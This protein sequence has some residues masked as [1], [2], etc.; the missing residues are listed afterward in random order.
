MNEENTKTQEGKTKKCFVIMPISDVEGYPKGHFDRV[1]KHVIVPAC[2]KTGYEA[3]RADGTS[4]ANV[5]IVDILKNALDCEMAIC[6]LSARN[7]NVFYELGF[8]QAFD[9]KTVLMI[10]DKTNRPFDISAIRSFTYDS[11]L[12]I[13]LVDKAISD[14]V[15]TLQETQSMTESE[16]NSLLKLLAIESPAILPKRKVISEDSSLILQAIHDLSDDI[17]K[18]LPKS[19]RPFHSNII[20]SILLKGQ[21]VKVGNH[22]FDE[23]NKKD[24]GYVVDIRDNTIVVRNQDGMVSFISLNSPE[25][26]N[27]KVMPF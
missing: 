1:F 8:R 10:D 11:S 22:L 26:D 3:I 16:N 18:N 4:K 24:I 21:I 17:Q 12:R 19:K 15:K 5:I 25:T 14:L 27:Y 20:N 23:K 2:K 7:P 13:D 6:D 9:K